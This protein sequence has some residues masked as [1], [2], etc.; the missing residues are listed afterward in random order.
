MCDVVCKCAEN[1]RPPASGACGAPVARQTARGQ[2]C[3]RE[4]LKGHTVQ[5]NCQKM[6]TVIHNHFG[7]YLYLVDTL[8]FG[9]QH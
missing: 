2:G 7:L 3:A 4:M 8:R 1:A 5:M 6:H 9:L